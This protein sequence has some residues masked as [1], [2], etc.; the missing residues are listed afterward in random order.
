MRWVEAGEGWRKFISRSL[1][2][3]LQP[4][5]CIFL[6]VSRCKANRTLGASVSSSSKFECCSFSIWKYFRRPCVPFICCATLLHLQLQFSFRFFSSFFCRRLWRGCFV[7]AS[8][9][10]NFCMREHLV[11]FH[12]V[13]FRSTIPHSIGMTFGILS[14]AF[15]SY[16]VP[17]STSA[18]FRVLGTR[19]HCSRS[20]QYF[21]FLT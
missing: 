3:A 12:C 16:L 19:T 10:K 1:L 18:S 6:S 15:V 9:K 5:R 4:R 8:G 21:S 2:L 14:L 20:R 7:L 17:H 13:S 11:D